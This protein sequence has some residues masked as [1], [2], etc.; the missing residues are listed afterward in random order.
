[1]L[2]RPFVVLMERSPESLREG[3]PKASSQAQVAAPQQIERLSVA[4]ENAP[5][6]VEND[7]TVRGALENELASADFQAIARQAAF[8]CHR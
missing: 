2:Q 5:I 3:L 4:I 1:M 8:R 7:H 6:A